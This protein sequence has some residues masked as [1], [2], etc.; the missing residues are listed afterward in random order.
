MIFPLIPLTIIRWTLG[1]DRKG[2]PEEATSGFEWRASQTIGS[3]KSLLIFIMASDGLQ[4]SE[5]IFVFTADRSLL[6]LVWDEFLCMPTVLERPGLLFRAVSSLRERSS[7]PGSAET[8]PADPEREEDSLSGREPP[9]SRVEPTEC[10]KD[11]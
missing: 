5:A 6:P 11:G 7:S 3:S 2:K 1:R 10:K 8:L 9:S 4:G